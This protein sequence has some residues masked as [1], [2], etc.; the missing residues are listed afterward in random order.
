MLKKLIILA[1]S[2][3]AIGTNLTV[4]AMTVYTDEIPQEHLNRVKS[5]NK[6]NADLLQIEDFKPEQEVKIYSEIK[7][8][9]VNLY[10]KV[11][12]KVVMA[13]NILI[14]DKVEFYVAKDVFKNGKLYIRKGE[15]VT[16][17]VSKAEAYYPGANAPCEI[18]VQHFRTKDTNDNIIK[19]WGKVEN[20]GHEAGMIGS[21]FG[22]Q[23]FSTSATIKKKKIYTVYY[24]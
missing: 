6:D 12:G 7:L 14:N 19:L 22:I 15:M 4:N 9:P 20:I 11:N 8:M 24:K 5:L 16:G 1:L 17:L 2:A 23:N 13:Q 18:Q 10:K 21:L 3:L